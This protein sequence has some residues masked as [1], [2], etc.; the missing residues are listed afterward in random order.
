MKYFFIEFPLRN[1]PNAEMTPK[2]K[3]VEI[4]DIP[5]ADEL[6]IPAIPSKPLHPAFPPNK[7]VLIL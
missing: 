4:R 7:G 3:R 6:N 1:S 5:S 2:I